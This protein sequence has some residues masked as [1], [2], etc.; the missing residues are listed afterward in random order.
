MK[1]PTEK[2]TR[3]RRTQRK[4]LPAPRGPAQE[5][6]VIRGARVN[7]LR[8]ISLTLPRNA[9]ILLTGV[10]GSGKS[11]L[12][13]DTLYAEGQRR[14]VESLSSYARQ[15]LERM[16]K[17]DVDL[18]Q[19]ISPAI[20][21]EQKTTS[22]NPR[23]TVATSTEIYDYLRLLFGR[24]GQ[25]YC[26]VCGDLITPDTVSSVVDALLRESEGTRCIIGFPMH[27][28]P[29][30]PLQEEIA[31][32]RKRGFTRLLRDGTFVDT[33]SQ[34]VTGKSKKGIVVV[35]DRIAIRHDEDTRTRLADSVHTA[36]VEGE[37]RAVLW[38]ADAGTHTAATQFRE[39]PRDG[40]SF[41]DTDPRMFSFNNP[42]GACPTCQGFG[43]SIGV[44]MDLVVPQPGKTL[45]EGAVVPW[46]FPR[47]RENQR[48]LI[49][50]APSA[51]VRLDVPWRDLSDEERMKVMRGWKGF[52]GIDGFFRYLEKKSY[53]LHY[54][55]F[56]SRFRGY[57]TCVECGGSRLRKDALCVRIAGKT[58]H[59]IVRSTIDD[60][61]RF[62]NGISLTQY[63]QSV[64][65]RILDEIRK[66]LEFL[67]RVGLGYLT[68]DRLSMTL[69]GGESQRIN[70]A[71][72]LGSSLMGSLY[73]LDEPSIGLH[74]RDGDRL[75]ELLKSL[76]DLGNT[77]L[78]VEHDEDMIRQADHV[79]ELGPHAGEQG[80]EIVYE[81]SVDKMLRHERSLTGQY[82]SGSKSI[83]VPPSRGDDSEQSIF[84]RGASEHNLRDIDVRIPL[85][86][87]VV[88]TGVSGSGKSTLV[89][90]VLYANLQK[91][92][93]GFD[94]TPGRCK[95]I[96]GG[97]NIDRVELV[98]Q[99][100][101]GRSPRSNPVT[102][103]KA[104]DH[105]REIFAATPA[106]RARGFRPG[107]FS[108]NVP[109]GRCDTC[110]GDGVQR[111]EMQFLA[112]VILTCD[113][114]KGKRYKQEV[115]EIRY[116]GKNIDDI[117]RMTVEEALSFFSESAEG[118]KVVR[119]LRIL[120]E[121]GLGY[122]RLGQPATTLSGGEAQRMK[123]ALHL[124]GSE[125]A[126]SALFIFD[127]PT[128]GLHL[129]DIA[130]LLACFRRLLDA[131]H[132]V[133]IIEHNLH[134]IK[135]ADFIIDLGPEAGDKGGT[136]VVTGSPEE[137]AAHNASWTGRYL[138]PLLGKGTKKGVKVSTRNRSEG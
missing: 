7:N 101:I 25:T 10:S 9:L 121:V 50:A 85:Q 38:N 26:P 88:V 75:M 128:T 100:P 51:G 54:R 133:L 11:S 76:R 35:V 53:K 31:V 102:Y 81:G 48:D 27:D 1:T 39:C 80:G 111:I 21:I 13:F 83:P 90:S 70:L 22:R 30:R 134:V 74:P 18:I 59:D 64:A 61:L 49:Q 113:A 96:D 62:F 118:A 125:G 130:T 116:R 99:S 117:L 124:S 55:V 122:L 12:A 24:I 17:P 104:F 16:E 86:R 29:G 52:D 110:E 56:L 109:G 20:A 43:R 71:T 19:G 40:I 8:N 14:Y 137:V 98:D 57:T 135:T 45:R 4:V 114:C 138:R 47:W 127:E 87:L 97:T 37:G 126:G 123:L 136:V 95:R 32:L 115:L 92:K 84:I 6:I 41:E 34:K 23:S 119:K 66:R 79:V 93:G 82:L 94:G 68:L 5:D 91:Q 129:D 120:T 3:S 112:D 132:S 33:D 2:T 36:F 69:S 131:G 77:V 67:S 65:R 60:A 58:I 63:E 46:M 106:A 78:V 72:S 103:V 44:D 28:H 73:V 89:H 108:F 15:F 107:H 42:F 105:I